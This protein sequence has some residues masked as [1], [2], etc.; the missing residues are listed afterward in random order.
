MYILITIDCENTYR[1]F[2]FNDFTLVNMDGKSYG[3]P[4]IMEALDKRG[5]KGNFFLDTCA[6]E[7][8]GNDTVASVASLISEQ[9]HEVELHTH[10][11]DGDFCRIG[12]EKQKEIIERGIALIKS[13]ARKPPYAFRAGSYM[14]DESGLAILKEYGIT[15]DC[16]NYYGVSPL[17]V[18]RNAVKKINGIYEFP[19]SFFRLHISPAISTFN[20]I[21]GTHLLYNGNCK[22]DINWMNIS[23]LKRVIDTFALN[24][25]A[26]L[27]I[28]LHSYSFADEKKLAQGK[29]GKDVIKGEVIKRFNG[30]L[31]YFSSENEFEVV[32]IKWLLEKMNE[33]NNFSEKILSA[34]DYVPH[35]IWGIDVSH[36]RLKR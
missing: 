10:P 34:P 35:D 17:S 13:V 12:R 7:Y 6:A 29:R 24:G 27:V 23:G 21:A 5:I 31:D 18:T 1:Q 3:I 14:M 11:L 2:P 26:V 36:L 28:F 20:R 19:V 4:M 8:Y 9:G 25:T 30:L 15:A 33:D 22:L 32:T 16:S